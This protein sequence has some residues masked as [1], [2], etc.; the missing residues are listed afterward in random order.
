MRVPLSFVRHQVPMLQAFGRTAANALRQR[1]S[2]SKPQ[3]ELPGQ[4]LSATLPPRPR[5]LVDAYLAHVS[6][7]AS[8]NH[9]GPYLP[10][11]LFPQWGFPLLQAALAPIPYPLMDLLNGG[12]RMVVHA[13]LPAD[14]PLDVTAQLI[15]IDDDGKRAIMHL[16]LL[17]G[18]R[19]VPEAL[20]VDFQ[21]IVRL[22]RKS[23]NEPQRARPT[24]PQDATE[25]ARWSLDARAGLEF[26]LLTGDFNPIHWVPLAAKAAG[27]R[28]VILHGFASMSRAAEQLVSELPPT[29]A[30]A[31]LALRE[32][33]V[34]FVKPLVLPANVGLYRLGSGLSVGPA[35]G[36]EAFMVGTFALSSD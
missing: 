35:P 22:R 1:L 29:A 19:S 14:E 11:H 12:C 28:S 25:L 23:D 4:V 2:R 26:A 18:T 32:M 33:D 15:R 13:P 5:E 30:P 21:A 20:E 10:S 16:R 27:F 34:R 3:L 7:R 8:A 9:W 36:D 31:G 17:T 6:P 24:V